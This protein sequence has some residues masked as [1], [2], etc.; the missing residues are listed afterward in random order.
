MDDRDPDDNHRTL[1]CIV[2]GESTTVNVTAHVNDEVDDLKELLSI[3]IN[4]ISRDDRGSSNLEGA[5]D[6]THIVVAV[7]DQVLAAPYSR[8]R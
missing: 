4:R 5:L 7:A 1:Q 2:S 3:E 8:A 6:S